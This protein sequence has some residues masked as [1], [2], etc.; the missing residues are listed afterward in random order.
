MQ[1]LDGILCENM[2]IS[3]LFPFGSGGI[4]EG[5]CVRF[6]LRM[7]MRFSF[8]FIFIFMIFLASIM[9][10]ECMRPWAFHCAHVDENCLLLCHGFDKVLTRRHLPGGSEGEFD[11]MECGYEYRE[12]RTKIGENGEN[13]LYLLRRFI[14][15]TRFELRQ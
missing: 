9:H 8:I 10:S 12:F 2:I 3:P 7:C 5:F 13:D 4:S 14:N 1:I 11:R 15:P 6:I